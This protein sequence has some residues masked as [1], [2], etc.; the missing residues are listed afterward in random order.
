MRAFFTKLPRTALLVALLG[1]AGTT[2]HAAAQAPANRIQLRDAGSRIDLDLA[3]GTA[4]GVIFVPKGAGPTQVSMTSF[5]LNSGMV[6]APAPPNTL[7]QQTAVDTGTGTFPAGGPYFITVD[8][9]KLQGAACSQNPSCIR[10]DLVSSTTVAGQTTYNFRV[11]STCRHAISYVA[12]EL[13]AGVKAVSPNGTFTG[14]NGRSYG[15]ENTTKNPFHSIKF[16]T[17]GG[18]EFK[19]GQSELFSFTL[20]AGTALPNPMRIQT[21]SGQD[22]VEGS[23]NGTTFTYKQGTFG[24]ALT[25][26]AGGVTTECPFTF[27]QVDLYTGPIQTDKEVIANT[28]GNMLIAYAIYQ[29]DGSPPRIPALDRSPLGGDLAIEALADALGQSFPNPFRGRTTIPVALAEAT[30]AR[31]DVF[32]VMGRRVATLLDEALSAG[33]YTVEFDAAALPAGL[34]VYRLTTATATRTGRMTLVN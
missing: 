20:P 22:I 7:A 34:Y 27:F 1:L 15:V 12:F 32:D 31:L 26:I 11:T 25:P 5:L 33:S 2:Q 3:A 8:L 10:F 21:K 24:G 18:T 4:T 6:Y 29:N 28:P 19:N 30:H 9:P 16:E 14:T 17:R 13:P 23:Y